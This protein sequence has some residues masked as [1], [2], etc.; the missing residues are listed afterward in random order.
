MPMRATRSTVT[1]ARRESAAVCTMRVVMSRRA[2]SSARSVCL[3]S[4]AVMISGARRVATVFLRS[5][6][7][8]VPSADSH[9]SAREAQP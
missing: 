6:V 4:M 1:Q 9:F 2:S 8:R 5:M 3:R 7:A